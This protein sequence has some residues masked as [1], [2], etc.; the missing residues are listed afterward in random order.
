MSNPS[1][2][3]R[4]QTEE[5]AA[6]IKKELTPQISQFFAS[7]EGWAKQFTGVTSAVLSNSEVVETV[8]D[9]VT[10]NFRYAC[11]RSAFF[12][13]RIL[14]YMDFQAEFVVKF[15]KLGL[16]GWSRLG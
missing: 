11:F 1:K 3:S 10:M 14:G 16:A 2:L 4:S 12:G 8:S 15:G 7:H 9:S 13:D 5:I 6:A